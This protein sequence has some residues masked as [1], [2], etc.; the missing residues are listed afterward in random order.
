MPI[1]AAVL[2]RQRA[3][4]GAVCGAFFIQIRLFSMRRSMHRC[5]LSVGLA[6]SLAVLHVGAQGRSINAF[7]D[8][9][10]ADWVRTNP[11]QA[12]SSRY[13]TGA[14][15]ATLET[16]VTP[17]TREW[18]QRRIALA[19]RGLEE[20]KAFDRARLTDV[21]RVSADLMSWQLGIVIE[22]EK[23]EDFSFPLEQFGGANIT[24]VNTLTVTHPIASEK[25]AVNYIARLR[26]VAARMDEATS[27]AVQRAEKRL[28]PPRFIVGLTITQME[29]FI[30][31]PAAQSP[32][33]TA[34][35]DRMAAAA[36]IPAGRREAL[37]AEAE[38]ITASQIYPAWRNALNVLRPLQGRAADAAG[39]SRFPGGAE[40]YAY[41][42]RAFTSTN[43]SADQ[44]HQI[45][46]REVARLETEMD[47]I[48]RRLGRTQGTLLQRIEQ[49]KKDLAYPL[50]DDGRV[51]IMRDIDG[52][53]RDAQQRSMLLFDK[54]P[55]AAVVA[56]PY[57]RFREATAAA[58]YNGPSPDGSRP[59]TF[60]MPL[61]P[62][63]MTRFGLR[64]LV[65]HETV[66]GH[67]FQI[68]LELENTANPRFRQIR[69][70]GGISAFSEG[71]G[72]YAERLAAENGWYENDLEGLLGQ[73]DAAL[74]RARRLVVDTGIHAKGWTRQQAIEYGIE[75]S[76]VERYVVNPGQACAYMI[77]QLKLVELRDKARSALGARFDPKPYHNFVLMSGTL[78]LTLLESEVGRYIAQATPR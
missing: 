64:T 65:Y 61:R 15:Q 67:H 1:I 34:F 69:A 50:T 47:G 45:G 75:A 59:G 7:F 40:A 14:E 21:E 4:P 20:L 55:R 5:L 38:Q 44:I 28:L 13:F 26:Q 39:L 18:R 22:A 37:R 73:L 17:L 63:R 76:E 54:T 19:R 41:F 66:P 16:Q 48:F 62:S 71:W 9:F 42:L 72:L 43:L 58:S 23:Y 25:D 3:P 36:A 46:L 6:C 56:Q 35:N 27:E 51:Q 29:Q 68:A 10:T 77:G 32:F 57:P 30:G 33:V 78:P 52:Y 11:N 2:L 8:E 60:Q 53:I 70:L 49:L 24:L 31:T 12:T 74:F